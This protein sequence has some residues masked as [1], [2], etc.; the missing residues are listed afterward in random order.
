LTNS[1][2]IAAG[3]CALWMVSTPGRRVAAS[4]PLPANMI[5]GTRSTQALYSAIDACCRPTVP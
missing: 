3:S 5:S 4:M 2:T 1:R